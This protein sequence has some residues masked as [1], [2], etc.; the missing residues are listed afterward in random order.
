MNMYIDKKYINMMSPKL[1]RFAWKKETLANCRCP[2]C[3]DSTKN[4]TKARGYFYI[5]GN[6]YFFKCHNCNHGCNIYNLLKMVYPSLCK[7]YTLEQ[8]KDEK[9]EAPKQKKKETPIIQRKTINEDLLQCMQPLSKLPEDNVAVVY[10]T[11]RGISTEH[12]D[13]LFYT[14]DFSKVM[15]LVDLNCLTAG[16][17]ERLVIPFYNKQGKIVG[18]Q[19]RILKETRKKN[20]AKYLTV[21]ASSNAGRL[22]Y[23]QWDVNPSKR[24]YVVE[25]P[26]DSLFLDNSVALVGAGAIDD[27]PIHF[28][29]SDM[30]YVLDNEPRNKQIVDYNKKLLEKGK[31]IC[32]WPDGMKEKDIN[33]MAQT[34][35]SDE[36]KNVIDQNI[37]EGLSGLV[38]LNQWKKV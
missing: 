30:V 23:R 29:G 18:C 9:K 20:A 7:E 3:G 25:G 21:K 10:A 5:K 1:E 17:E 26:I 35:S 2:V 13:K 15:K 12:W 31:S 38:R 14:D 19:G 6:A 11:K 28:Q 22:W 16:A 33:D 34:M 27:I 37:F 4:K 8:F 36:I 24:I 32:I